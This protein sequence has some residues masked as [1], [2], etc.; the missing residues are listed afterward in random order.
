MKT[1][2]LARPSLHSVVRLA[3]LQRLP[4]LLGLVLQVVPLLQAAQHQTVEDVLAGLLDQ[5]LEQTQRHDADLVTTNAQWVGLGCFL[6]THYSSGFTALAVIFNH[7]HFTDPQFD[8]QYRL[9][10][11]I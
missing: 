10:T 2:R 1:R 7:F 4:V 3:V 6:R 9:W 8:K 5:M 11:P